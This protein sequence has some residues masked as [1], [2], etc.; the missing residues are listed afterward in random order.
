MHR[1]YNG[2][3]GYTDY[4]YT[5][6]N[7]ALR[8]SIVEGS[9]DDVA[10]IHHHR[11]KGA[12][13][14][15]FYTWEDEDDNDGYTMTVTTGA[16][17][18][19]TIAALDNDLSTP[20]DLTLV[21]DGT[22]SDLIIYMK[23]D[24]DTDGYQMTIDPDDDPTILWQSISSTGSADFDVTLQ[25]DGTAQNIVVRMIEE[26]NSDGY[27]ITTDTNN[28]DI[29]VEV[30]NNNAG[31]DFVMYLQSDTDSDDLHM[32]MLDGSQNDGY[33][34][35]VFT[36]D[37]PHVDISVIENGNSAEFL[38]NFIS[39]ADN[40]LVFNL[41]D[42]ESDGY[43]LTTTTDG[44]PDMTLTTVGGTAPFSLTMQSAGADSNLVVALQ[45]D[46]NTDGY[47]VT[48]SPDSTP[49]M[50]VAAVATAGDFDL[51]LHS[52]GADQ[53][54]VIRLSDDQ[55][56]DGYK[57]TT[58]PST[59]PTMSFETVVNGGDA[60]LA[61]SFLADGTDEDVVFTFRDNTNTD[62]Y[63]F[64]VNPA[65]SP[66]ITLAT[67]GGG[68]SDVT[69]ASSASDV[70]SIVRMLDS[71]STG[72]VL[73][74]DTSA[75]DFIIAIDDNSAGGDMEVKIE[76]STSSA[77]AA[78]Y[79]GDLS[80]NDGI[81]LHGTGSNTPSLTVSSIDDGSQVLVD[82]VLSAGT[83]T[84]ATLKMM[85]AS[86]GYSFEATTGA[87]DSASELTI[88][89]TDSNV[90]TTLNIEAGGSESAILRFQGDSTFNFLEIPDN[91][92][93]ALKIRSDDQATDLMTFQ[94]SNGNEKITFASGVQL[95]FFGATPV[96][97]Q[98]ALDAVGTTTLTTAPGA[99]AQ[100]TFNT[101]ISEIQTALRALEDEMNDARSIFSNLGLTN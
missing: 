40:D 60:P 47:S 43:K 33:S 34:I 59:T 97:Q 7:A 95:G 35:Q 101:I 9:A 81:K 36:D 62:G 10:Y 75:Q 18:A 37:T 86:Q 49:T 76:G 48:V 63:T 73:T 17:P 1:Q 80:S 83:D 25:S 74:S 98:T 91:V 46:Q 8:Y 28:R 92:G 2:F 42:S 94:T 6:Q 53:D 26:T 90:G 55:S 14:S 3:D 19:M 78:V 20:F 56:S 99:Y 70:D 27:V 57:I 68:A 66:T 54:V 32:Y 67:V 64:T 69:L 21:A 16:S 72:V 41:Y 77:G 45:D 5:D 79:L 58:D 89:N 22:D 93:T 61:F 23:D 71:D 11:S 52:G 82:V 88:S 65:A 84:S 24:Q 15:L 4:V 44:T 96:S 51:S 13:Q 38:M 50:T 85:D 87:T 100:G 29:T 39:D 12:D 31:A 30:D